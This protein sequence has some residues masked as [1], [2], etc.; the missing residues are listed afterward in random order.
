MLLL[1]VLINFGYFMNKEILKNAKLLNNPHVVKEMELVKRRKTSFLKKLSFATYKMPFGMYK[2]KQLYKVP[3]EYMEWLSKQ[4]WV[5]SLS[6]LEYLKQL[7]ELEL[8]PRQF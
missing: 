4:D 6:L 1:V 3:L 7:M 2:G 5:N 8:I